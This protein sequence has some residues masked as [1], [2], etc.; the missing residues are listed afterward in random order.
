MMILMAR[1]TI[2]N[3]ETLI[4]S[5][6]DNNDYDINNY[7]DHDIDVNNNDD[8]D[9]DDKWRRR[10]GRLKRSKQGK[11]DGNEVEKMK[12]KK[13]VKKDDWWGGAREGKLI[14]REREGGL[15]REELSYEV[16]LMKKDQSKKKKKTG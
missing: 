11:R 14:G 1:R 13:M 8:D 10:R 9:F 5:E 12:K 15:W 6:S 7:N 16:K 4:G 2:L 3:K